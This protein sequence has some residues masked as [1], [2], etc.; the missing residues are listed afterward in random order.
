MQSEGMGKVFDTDSC[1]KDR[2]NNDDGED[3]L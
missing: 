3:T 2:Q 1:I